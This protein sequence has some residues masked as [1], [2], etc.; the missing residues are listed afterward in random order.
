M[1][2]KSPI[3]VTP[4]IIVT[5]NGG[6]REG[7]KAFV[8][9]AKQNGMDGKPESGDQAMIEAAKV[10]ILARID[11]LPAELNHVIVRADG[12]ATLSGEQIHIY[13]NGTTAL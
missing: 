13:V 1:A 11:A 3:N 2:D 8:Q 6:T 9:N 5:P 12:R 7:V 10:L 4:W